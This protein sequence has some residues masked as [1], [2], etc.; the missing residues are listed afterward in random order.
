MNVVAIVAVDENN[1]IGYQGELLARI[2]EDMKRFKELTTASGMVIM[3]RNTWESMGKKPLPDRTNIVITRTPSEL[4]EKYSNQHQFF[5][6]LSS[7]RGFLDWADASGVAP[8]DAYVIGGASIYE[9]LLPLCDTVELTRIYKAFEK[10]D[11]Y[12]P[13][14]DSQEWKQVAESELKE[15]NG[16]QY[17]FITY[18]RI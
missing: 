11:A 2:P 14:L 4:V 15:Y 9:Q 18:K 16:L 8:G 17:Q 12:F 6:N 3:G 5:M 10:V 7:A 1:G 13:L